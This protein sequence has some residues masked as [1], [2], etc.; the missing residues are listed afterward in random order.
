MLSI[1][2]VLGS[3]VCQRQVLSLIGYGGA[4]PLDEPDVSS[5]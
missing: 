2:V 5:R 3:R 1:A 4:E